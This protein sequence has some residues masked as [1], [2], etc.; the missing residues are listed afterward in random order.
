MTS[1]H[2]ASATLAHFNPEAE[3]TPTALPFRKLIQREAREDHR[4]HVAE[5]YQKG[6]A[7]G[8]A[9]ALAECELQYAA[10]LTAIKEVQLAERAAWVTKE[11]HRLCEDLKEGLQ[12]LE[13]RIANAAARTLAPVMEAALVQMAK[14]E[15]EIKLGAVLTDGVSCKIAAKGP[16]DLMD[17]LSAIA[18][19]AC[20]VSC[21]TDGPELTLV[22]EDTTLKTTLTTWINRFR[23]DVNE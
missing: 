13:H 10:K 20:E 1:F 6:I 14:K 8:R 23:Q 21:T 4:A 9:A 18:P 5:A 17:F 22:I 3:V 16:Q 15:L 7:E 2:P 19:T 11:S 12:S